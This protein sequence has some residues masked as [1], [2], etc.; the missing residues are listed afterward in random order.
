MQVKTLIKPCKGLKRN[1]NSRV[2]QGVRTS[3]NANKTLQGIKTP[4]MMGISMLVAS[5][6]ANKTLQGIKTAW[7]CSRRRRIVCEN[8]NKTLQG[9]KTPLLFWGISTTLRENANKT[10]QGIKTN[11]GIILE[12]QH[13]VWKR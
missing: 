11:I 4:I 2:E 8:A 13:F 3:E 12:Q 5:E 6:N 1:R 10:L 7:C 9:I